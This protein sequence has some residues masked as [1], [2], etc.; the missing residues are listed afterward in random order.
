MKDFLIVIP[1][2]MG[3]TRL[4]GKVL[5][6]LGGRPVV[7]WCRRAA[8]A[9]KL[10]PV[11]VATDS[12]K[13]RNALK[14]FGAT[15]VMTPESCESGSD[16]VWAVANKREY[17]GYR[18]IVNLQ[19]D[20]PF[21]TASTVKKAVK[22]LRKKAKA[23]IATAVVPLKRSDVAV[24]PHLVKAVVAKDGLCLYFSRSLVPWAANHANGNSANPSGY[25]GHLGLYVYR[26]EALKRFVG[27][28]PSPL[29]Q[30]ERLEQLRAL[31]A[32]MRI[33]AATVND[34]LVA[35]DTPKDL[36]RARHMLSKSGRIIRHG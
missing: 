30:R 24:N 36:L 29:E 20:A 27:M 22:A 14:P 1:A 25:Y 19:G 7:E 32:G 21:I 13:V 18:T 33:V 12:E 26:R 28:E 16:R 2:R 17:R 23:D 35:I 6:D 4:P 34:S 3:S 11:V 9:A 31:E 15:V 5:A 8:I 10:G